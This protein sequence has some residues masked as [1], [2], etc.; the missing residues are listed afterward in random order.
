MGLESSCF[1]FLLQN[2]NEWNFEDRIYMQWTAGGNESVKCTIS[3]HHKNRDERKE[4][5]FRKKR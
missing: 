3:A 5:L 1:L 2:K 4:A